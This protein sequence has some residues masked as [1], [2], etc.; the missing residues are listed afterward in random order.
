[1][2]NSAK[3]MAELN[4]TQPAAITNFKRPFVAGVVLTTAQHV[5]MAAKTLSE[6]TSSIIIGVSSTADIRHAHAVVTACQ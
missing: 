5:F 3:W 4:T 2:M 6:P 1:M